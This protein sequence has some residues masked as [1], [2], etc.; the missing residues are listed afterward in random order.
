MGSERSESRFQL[1][2]RPEP[3]YLPEHFVWWDSIGGEDVDALQAA[4]DSATRESDMQTYL[5]AHPHMLIQHLGGGHG[6]WVIPQK[7][8]GAEFVPDFVIG[9]RDSMG[10][11][12]QI[13]E[14]ESPIARLFTKKGDPTQALTH[15]IRQITDW[16]TWLTPN[17]GYAARPREKSGLGLTDISNRAPGLIIIGRR[18]SLDAATHERRRQMCAQTQIAIHTYDWL[19]S[20]ARGR[21][22]SLERSQ[23]PSS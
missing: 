5:E 8:L 20:A 14:L 1:A 22:G 9:Q 6:R 23:R 11:E 10:F 19:M 4:L 16:R 13:V 12:W 3:D 7:R 2:A 15:A 17:Q 18:S 21:L